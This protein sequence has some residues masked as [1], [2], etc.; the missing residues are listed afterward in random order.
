MLAK[1]F[2]QKADSNSREREITCLKNCNSKL[3]PIG[4]N[5]DIYSS[6]R[7]VSK[8]AAADRKLPPRHWWNFL[9]V[10]VSFFNCLR[11]RGFKFR[12]KCNN[13]VGNSFNGMSAV[14]R[15][16][17]RS[18]LR[19]DENWLCFTLGGITEM[20]TPWAPPGEGPFSSNAPLLG[21][22]P[23]LTP[24]LW[25]ATISSGNNGLQ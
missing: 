25:P 7:V 22:Y 5:P 10:S 24:Q 14:K 13:G 6:D 23:T 20:R 1:L 4:D 12:Y 17:G 16:G 8:L 2:A 21:C 9:P 11:R 18:V 19:N 15:C 3:P